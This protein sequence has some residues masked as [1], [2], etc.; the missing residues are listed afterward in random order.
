MPTRFLSSVPYRRKAVR[1][2]KDSMARTYSCRWKHPT[3]SRVR[4]HKISECIQSP[5]VAQAYKK[6]GSAKNH[7][8][9]THPTPYPTCGLQRSSPCYPP[10]YGTLSSGDQYN[11]LACY[12]PV[13]EVS[14]II[15]LNIALSPCPR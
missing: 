11:W 12:H 2:P 13:D 9:R 6:P 7:R 15:H 14:S 1:C 8:I 10:C 4:V 3:S 5:L